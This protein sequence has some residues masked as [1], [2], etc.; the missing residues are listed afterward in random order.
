[1]S[2]GVARSSSPRQAGVECAA[3]PRRR[4]LLRRERC[5]RLHLGQDGMEQS[6]RPQSTSR[7]DAVMSRTGYHRHVTAIIA[8]IAVTATDVDIDD[9]YIMNASTHTS[10][11]PAASTFYFQQASAHLRR[12]PM[13]TFLEW[14]RLAFGPGNGRRVLDS[15]TI[16]GNRRRLPSLR[17]RIGRC[18]KR[19]MCAISDQKLHPRVRRPVRSTGQVAG[20]KRSKAAPALPPAPS[21]RLRYRR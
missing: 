20:G 19:F 5:R 10:V 8:S 6:P 21:S 15:G 12:R 1:M 14:R 7:K 2:G 3:T 13:G 11:M 16:A 18:E 4:R 17:C 9:F